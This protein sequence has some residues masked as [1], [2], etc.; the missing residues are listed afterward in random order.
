MEKTN[1]R[2]VYESPALIEIGSMEE[3]T[4]TFWWG[5][6][7]WWYGGHK[8]GHKGGHHGGHGHPNSPDS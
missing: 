8:G 1:V 5:G 6:G 2:K 7:G 4:E 3:I